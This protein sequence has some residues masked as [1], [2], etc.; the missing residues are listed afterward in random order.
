MELRVVY[1][2]FTFALAYLIRVSKRSAVTFVQRLK[3]PPKKAPTSL[4]RTTLSRSRRSPSEYGHLDRA[5]L[6][7]TSTDSI[8]NRGFD[9]RLASTDVAES[10]SSG[11]AAYATACHLSVAG[12]RKCC[13]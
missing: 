4:E 7:L 3:A 8:Q 11:I 1:I 9:A 5:R 10:H 6:C 13:R 12:R 2:A